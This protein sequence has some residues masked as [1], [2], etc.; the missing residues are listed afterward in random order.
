MPRRQL[1]SPQARSSLF[2]PPRD[3]ALVV[4]FHTLSPA[5]LALIR[6]RR[7]PANC[8][9]FAIQLAYLRHPGRAIEAGEV[10]PEAMLAFIA[11]QL[12]VS[13][14]TF[15][16][17]ARR[18]P[19]RREHLLELQAALGLKAF[20]LGDYRSLSAWALEV[21]RQTDRGEA[22]IAALVEEVRRR[23]IILPSPSVLERIGLSS[24]ARARARARA[25]AHAKLVAGLTATQ[26]EELHGLLSIEEDQSRTRFAW[27]REWPEAPTAANLARI[28]ERLEAVCTLAIEAAHARRIHQARYALIAGAAR[29][30]SA[31]HLTRLEPARRLAILTAFAI[32]MEAELT[33]AAVQTF[34]RL[35]GALFRKARQQ[36]SERTLASANSLRAAARAHARSGRA[37][38]R[39]REA[40]AVMSI[41]GAPKGRGGGG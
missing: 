35:V 38:I 2:D 25:A 31:Q 14:A 27:L 4:R 28:I 41:E 5:D 6:R 39:A 18:D 33:D 26:R 17:Y 30:M 34:D 11:Q 21:A 10:P 22:I 40:R 9:G 15:L 16:G 8:L 20:G 3:P 36:R 24:R 13:P 37:L 23:R 19:T 1:L 12:G 32:E 29:A 7:R